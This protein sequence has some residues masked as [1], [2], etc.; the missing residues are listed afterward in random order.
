[1]YLTIVLVLKRVDFLSKRESKSLPN[2]GRRKRSFREN[3][4]KTRSAYKTMLSEKGKGH[5][6]GTMVTTV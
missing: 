3:S 4:F 1:M 6:M 2:E 5:V